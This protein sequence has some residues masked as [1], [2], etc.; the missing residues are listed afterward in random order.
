MGETEGATKRKEG[1][2]EIAASLASEFRKSCK[3]T[4]QHKK[5]VKRQE[6]V[7]SEKYFNQLDA[8]GRKKRDGKKAESGSCLGDVLTLSL[9]IAR[10]SERIGRTDKKKK[11]LI[12]GA[13]KSLILWREKKTGK[14]KRGNSCGPSSILEQTK[15]WTAK[16]KS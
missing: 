3:V 10:K 8:S 2:Y 4:G 13:K 15:Q 14:K 1:E 5:E 16:E 6:G 9:Q 7:G 11:L 12:G